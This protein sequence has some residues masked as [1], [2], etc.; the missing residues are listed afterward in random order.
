MWANLESKMRSHTGN[1]KDPN[2]LYLAACNQPGMV[3]GEL[4]VLPV[5]HADAHNPGPRDI[6]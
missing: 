5:G 6:K 2:R 3:A 4:C 1:L